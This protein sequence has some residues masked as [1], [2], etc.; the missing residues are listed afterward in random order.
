MTKSVGLF[1]EIV[2]ALGLPI[3]LMGANE[4]ILAARPILLGIGGIYAGLLLSRSHATHRDIGLTRDRLL[5]ALRSLIVP[6]LVTVAT[7]LFIMSLTPPATRLWMIGSDPLSVPELSNRLIFY[8]FGSSPVQE[9][10]FRGYL[11]YRL[12]QVFSRKIWIV[13]ISTLIFILAHVPFKS[14]ILLLVAAMLGVYYILN[15]L[16]YKNLFAVAISHGFVGSI[17]IIVRNFYLPYQ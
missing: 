13:F 8:I 6:S 15:Y 4:F 3:Y 1:I 14:P 5:P 7:V 9:L 10:I 12:E 16:K 2:V 17:L 11:T